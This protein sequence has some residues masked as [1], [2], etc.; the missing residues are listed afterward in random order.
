MET[1]TGKG[2]TGPSILVTVI[3]LAL[4]AAALIANPSDYTLY[5]A[6]RAAAML[7]YIYVFFSCLSSAFVRE[8][9][10]HFGRP[11]LKIHHTLATVGLTL[12]TVHG[13]AAAWDSQSIAVFLPRFGSPEGFL[14]WGGPPAYWL[15][16]IA[17]A[18][19]AA[20]L[21]IGVRWRVLHWLNYIA[22]MLASAHALMIGSDLEHRAPRWVV[23]AM[24]LVVIAVFISKR[25]IEAKR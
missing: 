7:G 11:Y 9:T 22:F 3:P 14:S 18:A 20:R 4:V 13:A 10:R 21:S 15:I 23:T 25:L 12:L 2:A 8:L 19:A 24:V 6:I 1:Q 5:T 16:W 17:V